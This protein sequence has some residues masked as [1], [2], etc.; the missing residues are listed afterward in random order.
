MHLDAQY[1]TRSDGRESLDI[2]GRMSFNLN[3]L[4]LTGELSWEQQFSEFGPAPS[5]RIG[6][7]LLANGRIGKVRLR[8]EAIYRVAPEKRF[9]QVNFTGEWRAGERSDWRAELGY[10]A[11]LDRGRAAIGIIRRFERFSLTA[12]AEAAT[13]GSIAAG[14]NLAFSLGP[15]PRNGKFRFSSN[16]LANNGQALAIVFH[17]ENRDGIRQPGESL[18]ENVELTAGQSAAFTATDIRGR[19]VIDNLQP[20]R[21]VLIG[22]DSSSLSSPYVQP[23]LPGVVITP[24]PGIA[25]TVELPLVSAGEVE[26]TLVRRGG[27]TIA[28]VGLEL[29]DGEGRVVRETRTEFDGFFLFDGVPYGSY[30]VRIEKLSAQAIRVPT[31]LTARAVVD[32]DNQVARLGAV[33]VGSTGNMVANDRDSPE[34]TGTP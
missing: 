8:G 19:A 21:P 27:G 32:D 34:P 33:T 2:T 22:I 15:D 1:E 26:G 14:L 11:G 6:A 4:S 25:T 24:R 20:F 12:T 31:Q 30:T 23:A 17:D 16:K 29:L 3:R 7:R 10:D 18:A 5:D 28:G 9:E 13:D